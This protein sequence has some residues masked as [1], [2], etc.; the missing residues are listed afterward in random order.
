LKNILE[1][2][3]LE[4]SLEARKINILHVAFAI[5]QVMQ[6][7]IVGMWEANMSLLQEARSHGEVL[8]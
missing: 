2:K 3:I 5:S 8:P 1:A 4:I 7:K 6:K